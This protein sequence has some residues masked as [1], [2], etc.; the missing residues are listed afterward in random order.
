MIYAR[1]WLLGV[2]GH[3]SLKS[4]DFYGFPKCGISELTMALPPRAIFF[5]FF[6]ACGLAL[7]AA[8]HP[9]EHGRRENELILCKLQLP[10][11][12]GG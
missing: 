9:L 11:L 5:F 8:S 4:P 6:L 3:R 12:S 7:S 10:V 1:G 2:T